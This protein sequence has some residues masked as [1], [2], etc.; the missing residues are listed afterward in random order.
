MK[1]FWKNTK[2]T[3]LYAGQAMML[4]MI[5]LSCLA[6]LPFVMLHGLVLHCT[7]L[8]LAASKKLQGEP[9][10]SWIFQNGRREPLY[11]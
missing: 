8:I 10:Q 6:A 4:P 3:L 9:S 2:I 5:I 11:T 7:D 1:K